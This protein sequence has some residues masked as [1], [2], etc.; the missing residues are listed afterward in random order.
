MQQEDLK[1]RGV[2]FVKYG[3]AGGIATAVYQG[4]FYLMG[5]FVL[6]AL[7]ADDPIVKWFG[8]SGFPATMEPVVRAQRVLVNGIV[9][10]LISNMVAYLINIWWVFRAGRHH[11]LV[12]IGLFYLVSGIS[13]GAGLGIMIWQIFHYEISTSLANVSLVITSLMLNYAMRKFVIFKG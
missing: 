11:W 8:L 9:G 13:F 10:F 7:L 4:L 3:L 6:P 1:S 2:Q 12:E 5:I